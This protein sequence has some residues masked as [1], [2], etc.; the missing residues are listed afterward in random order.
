MIK[1]LGI[2]FV[3]CQLLLGTIA[4]AENNKSDAFVYYV[5]FDVDTYAPVTTENIVEQSFCKL[6]FSGSSDVA[7]SLTY[8]LTAA[9]AGTFSNK[10]VR[11][12]VSMP[13]DV[14]I[15]VDTDGGVLIT[16]NELHKRLSGN[17]F[18]VLRALMESQFLN[19]DCS[20]K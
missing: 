16:G 15:F 14:D 1:F 3:L 6:S 13:N 20:S 18:T 4:Y 11:L 9:P 7:K 12:K 19:S 5:P 17:D 2:L 8:L 10:V